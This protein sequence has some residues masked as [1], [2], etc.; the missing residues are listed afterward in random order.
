MKTLKVMSIIGM[1]LFP[2]CFIFLVS[3]LGLNDNAAAGWGIIALF[4]AIPL[5][6][7]TFIQSK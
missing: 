3:L 5:S 7:V 4:Y 6:I 1:V 2:L